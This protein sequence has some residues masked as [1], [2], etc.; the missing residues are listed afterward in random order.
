MGGAGANPTVEEILNDA[1]KDENDRRS[2]TP[3]PPPPQERAHGRSL[4]Q[5]RKRRSPSPANAR[6][7]TPP[8]RR[9][10]R[11]SLPKERVGRSGGADRRRMLAHKKPA[12][13]AEKKPSLK[14]RLEAAER[15]LARQEPEPDTGDER[16][17]QELDYSL[18]DE[19]D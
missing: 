3:P 10:K 7:A 9:P 14:E 17:E 13:T 5:K 2:A 18:L 19:E 6:A 11:Q 4:P 16:A 15:E 1:Q 12:K 8:R